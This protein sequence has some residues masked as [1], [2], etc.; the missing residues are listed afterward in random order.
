MKKDIVTSENDIY[1]QEAERVAGKM[2]EK[3]AGT[4]SLFFQP[5]H[6][7]TPVQRKESTAA[8][9]EP[10]TPAVR[11]TLNSSGQPMDDATR[12][13]L[14]NRFGYDFGGVQ[15]HNDSLAHQS[16]S[17]INALAYTH[18]KHIVF[19][20]GQ[21]QPN[22]IS[23]K[24]L[25]AHELVHVIQQSS[26]NGSA[27]LVQRAIIPYGKIQW[28]DFLGKPPEKLGKEGAGIASGFDI[29]YPS[30]S[31]DTAVKQ[32]KKCK[33][34]KRADT[35]HQASITSSYPEVDKIT[36]YMDQD[37]SWVIDRIKTKGVA[38]C[39]GE[40]TNCEKN[41]DKDVKDDKAFCNSAKTNC[42]QSFKG[43][44]KDPYT[45]TLGKQ[46]VVA[47]AK[48]QCGFSFYEDCIRIAGTQ[49]QH[50]V[51]VG[52]ALVKKDCKT[53]ALKSCIADEANES[54][55]LLRHEQGHFDITKVIADRARQDLKDKAAAFVTKKIVCGKAEAAKI[56]GEMSSE[57]YKELETAGN[58]WTK[59]KDDVQD[60][61]DAET[62]NSADIKKQK[63]WEAKIKDGL[64]GY[65][66]VIV[67]APVTPVVPVTPSSPD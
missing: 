48:N 34:G 33:I 20:S 43:G 66:P 41:F 18:G 57:L 36:A 40:V 21:Y 4:G 16:S 52:Q 63:A 45:A 22:K 38:F 53:T 28:T 64:K 35:E 24:K 11:Q 3:P 44:S 14:E 29:Y 8:Y 46:K 19:G 39:A 17:E 23:G 31:P 32:K 55:R 25:L 15:I 54:D 37:K 56:A 51:G 58:A 60:V 50:N 10:V 27:N 42:E 49:H 26:G 7:I 65:N 30:T 47:Y 2:M 6:S 9:T 59:L 67:V 12:S 13:F 62:R 5:A 1:E 61:Y